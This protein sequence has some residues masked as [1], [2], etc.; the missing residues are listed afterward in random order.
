MAGLDYYSN[1]NTPSPDSEKKR[2]K[3]T[4]SESDNDDES[5]NIDELRSGKWTHEE[6]RFADSLIVRFEEGTLTDCPEG[7]TLR[8]YLTWKLHCMPMRVSKKY[9]AMHIG[10]HVFVKR[11]VDMPVND[12]FALKTLEKQCWDSIAQRMRKR[13][14][15]YSPTSVIIN[16]EHIPKSTTEL[17]KK[18]HSSCSL[19][20]LTDPLFDGLMDQS[21]DSSGEESFHFCIDDFLTL[22]DI[23]DIDWTLSAD[24]FSD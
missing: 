13:I 6:E 18:A 3:R 23:S 2:M 1:V 5:S 8:T 12:D 21:D 4:F 16:S 22:G 10:K 9:G 7:C 14:R 20:S 19:T 15:Q 17:I 24:I 11:T